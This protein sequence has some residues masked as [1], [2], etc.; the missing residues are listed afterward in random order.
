MDSITSFRIVEQLYLA[1]LHHLAGEG[2]R[3]PRCGN[4]RARHSWRYRWVLWAP[5][6]LDRLR[7][8]RVRCRRCRTVETCFPPWLFPYEVATVWV[9][10]A[11]CAAIAIAGQPW[12]A[13]ERQG[14]WPRHW[15]RRHVG[16]WLARAVI[17]RQRIAQQ[18]QAWGWP[19]PSWT[20]T[21]QPP[22]TARSADWAWVGVAWAW[23]VHT[24]A[25]EAVAA[26]IG[27]WAVWCALAP[28]ALP[29]D[30]FPARTHWGRRLRTTAAPP[31]LGLASR[32]LAHYGEGEGG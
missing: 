24:L 14:N 23:T 18:W 9:L 29:P 32:P 16:R 2:F 6:R 11:L 27:A 28:L 25:L 19:W 20:Q 30:V 17:C 4:R 13:V 7:L 10:A 3:C 1:F 21:W 15:L 5:G 31:G 22:A 8:L 26:Q 12:A